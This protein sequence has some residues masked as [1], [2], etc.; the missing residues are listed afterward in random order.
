MLALATTTK[1]FDLNFIYVF[2]QNYKM[3][4]KI[5][6]LYTFFLAAAF[7]YIIG[8]VVFYAWHYDTILIL[9]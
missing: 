2:K 3:F 6:N 7:E 5:L 4:L 9:R 8:F 1:F